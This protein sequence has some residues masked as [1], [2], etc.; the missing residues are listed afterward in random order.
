MDMAR[1]AMPE[2][3]YE[4]PISVSFMYVYIYTHMHAYVNVYMYIHAYVL[5]ILFAKEQACRIEPE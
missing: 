4:T 3:P 2:K 5:C 1:K